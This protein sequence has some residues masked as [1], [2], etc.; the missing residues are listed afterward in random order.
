MFEEE[1]FTL[2]ELMKYLRKVDV[3]EKTCKH[4][5]FRNKDFPLSRYDLQDMLKKGIIRKIGERKEN[6]VVSTAPKYYNPKTEKVLVDLQTGERIKNILDTQHNT[7][8]VAIETGK[9]IIENCIYYV[10]TLQVPSIKLMYAIKERIKEINK[11]LN[12]LL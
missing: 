6:R 7:T 11:E 1:R 12:G 9:Y 2:E 3:L 5:P 4:L 8:Y 10:Y